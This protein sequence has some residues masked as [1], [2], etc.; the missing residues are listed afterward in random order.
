MLTETV[1]LGFNATAASGRP[2]SCIGFVPGTQPDYSDAVGYSTA[3]SYYCLQSDGPDVGRKSVLGQR[4]TAGRTPWTTSLDLQ[5]AYVPK[6]AKG[7]L[8][9]QMDIFN[10]FNSQKVVEW[11]ETRDFSRATTVDTTTTV[12]PG[13]TPV[14]EGQLSKNYQRPTSFQQPRSVRLTA[15]YEF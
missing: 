15:R 13:T 11:N 7:K 10:F 5:F 2:T 6:M 1:R 12:P 3:S 8:S 14:V 9:L 4:G